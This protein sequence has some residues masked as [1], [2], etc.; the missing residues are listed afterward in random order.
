MSSIRDERRGK[1]SV[2]TIAARSVCSCALALVSHPRFAPAVERVV[3][4]IANI[5]NIY[6]Q[7]N[8]N[9]YTYAHTYKR[10]HFSNYT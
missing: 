7:I 10:I 8:I 3:V 4:E 1:M 6:I 9:A 5:M 2:G